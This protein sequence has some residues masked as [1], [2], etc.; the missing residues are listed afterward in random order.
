M[1][2]GRYVFTIGGSGE[3]SVVTWSQTQLQQQTEGPLASTSGMPG[4]PFTCTELAAAGSCAA[5]AG[6]C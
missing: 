4:G 2:Y 3:D 1:A 6:Q 5:A